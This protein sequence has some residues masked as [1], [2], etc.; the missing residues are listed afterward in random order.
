MSISLTKAP[1]KV[2][3]GVKNKHIYKHVHL[4]INDLIKI[5]SKIKL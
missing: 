3:E 5:I 4:W 1:L 2:K